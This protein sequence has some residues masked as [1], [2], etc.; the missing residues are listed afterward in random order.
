[1]RN[2]E[3]KKTW[4]QM[5]LLLHIF[6]FM[7]LGS[8]NNQTAFHPWLILPNYT[9]GSCCCIYMGKWTQFSNLKK[10]LV[11]KKHLFLIRNGET[12]S[13]FLCFFKWILVDLYTRF[14]TIKRWSQFT[15][16]WN[17]NTTIYVIITSMG[18]KIIQG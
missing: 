12:A 2:A 9:S 1:M 18:V 5:L 8:K 15:D 10:H 4:W 7:R 6:I 14:T 3:I 13:L 11:S 17:D 16:N